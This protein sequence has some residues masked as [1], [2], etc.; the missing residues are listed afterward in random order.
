MS[1]PSADENQMRRNARLKM[2]HSARDYHPEFLLA[3]LQKLQRSKEIALVRLVFNDLQRSAQ[4]GFR[5]L[6]Q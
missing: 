4:P 1:A 2:K 3:R 6:T 5:Y